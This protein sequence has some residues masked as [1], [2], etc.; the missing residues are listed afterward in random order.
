LTAEQI[1]GDYYGSASTLVEILLALDKGK[2]FKQFFDGIKEGKPADE[3]LKD[4]F[5][6]SYEDLKILYAQRIKSQLK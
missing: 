5:G 4:S 6:I 1:D 3:S 2:Q